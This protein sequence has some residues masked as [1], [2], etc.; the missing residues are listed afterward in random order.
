[1]TKYRV[2]FDKEEILRTLEE[3]E[4]KEIKEEDLVL[5]SGDLAWYVRHNLI[6]KEPFFPF[7]YITDEEGN[8]I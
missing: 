2:H 7:F 3:W 8:F 6:N 1:M 4:A 5:F